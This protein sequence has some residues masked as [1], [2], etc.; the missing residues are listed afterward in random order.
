MLSNLW[1]LF[2][3]LCFVY[4]ENSLIRKISNKK[5]SCFWATIEKKEQVHHKIRSQM[6]YKFDIYLHKNQKIAAHWHAY[7]SKMTPI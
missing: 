6:E 5:K 2:A 1:K 4:K 7:F 3:Y